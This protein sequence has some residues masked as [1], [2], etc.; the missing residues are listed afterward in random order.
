MES[1]GPESYFVH[2]PSRFSPDNL[3]GTGFMAMAANFAEG[4]QLQAGGCGC[5]HCTVY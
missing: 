2:I 1:F 5:S 4:S 3:Q